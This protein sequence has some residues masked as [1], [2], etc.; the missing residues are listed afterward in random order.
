MKPWC[1][2]R[3]K[4]EKEGVTETVE[5]RIA[6]GWL[7]AY[8]T[9]VEHSIGR[10]KRGGSGGKRKSGYDKEISKFSKQMRAVTREWM[11]ET[12]E[13]KKAGLAAQRREIRSE[14]QRRVR[15]GRSGAMMKKMRE[16][17]RMAMGGDGEGLVK[18]LQRW[19]GKG[20]AVTGGDRSKM[21][22]GQ[23][24]WVMGEEMKKRWRDTF[25]E[26]G[27]GLEAEE[28]FDEKIK[29]ITEAAVDGWTAG[30]AVEEEVE[31]EHE[32]NL[33]QTTLDG[34]VMRWEVRRA[35]KRL[36]DGKA[37]GV[38]GV[39][40]EVL[41]H[42][43]EW[44]EESVWRLCAAVFRGEVVPVE[45]LRAI[46]VPVKK[47]GVGDSFDQYRGVTL[48]SVVGKVFAMVVEA[49]L[50][51][52]CESRGVLTDCQFGFRQGRACRDA[53]LVVTEVLE[54]RGEGERV[55]LGFLDIAKAYPSVWR[56]GMWFRLWEIGVRGRMWRVVRSLYAKCEVAV[57][58]GGEAEDWYEEFVGLREGCVLSPLLFAI[59]INDLPAELE[60][61]KCGGVRMGG[62]VIR[63]LMFAD[64]VVMMASSA[65]ELQ[66]CFEAVGRFSVR[67]RFKFNFGQ[68]KTAVMV[69]GGVREG[70]RWELLGRD[71]QVVQDY[72][73]L[74]VRLMG[75]GGWTLRRKVLL[76][77]AR[78]AF[79]R[80]W[81]LGMGMGFLSPKAARG[82]WGTLVCPV[83]EYG[84]EVDSGAWEDA[85][86]MQR[87]AG[88]MCLGVGR[89]VPNVV[90]RG[91]LGWWT[92]RARREYLRLSYWGKV[93]REPVGGM[94]RDV[95]E[96]GRRRVER[97]EA[98]K[99]EWCVETKRLLGELGLGE[100]WV[101]ESVGGMRR[102]KARVKALMHEREEM[103]WRQEM[104]ERSTLGRYMRV[105]KGLK[106]EWFWGGGPSVGKKVGEVESECD[107]FG[108]VCWEE[109]EGVSG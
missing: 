99:G 83:M 36:R 74:G 15:R 29:T 105:K 56:K 54:R 46:K 80:A 79:W 44:M 67:W 92:V 35:I 19:S 43:G 38:D 16:I 68:D 11:R 10:E 97:G 94:V 3:S 42:G 70:E 81:G 87:L 96:E 40:A 41:K 9:V 106:A 6:A 18:A 34:D 103:R 61:G 59:Y 71:V 65:A 76:A 32:G 104:A 13:E 66:R 58:V 49:R 53:L 85:E 17:E 12:N 23:G 60:R 26:V 14:R 62:R 24:G 21:K 64:D 4:A 100:V 31:M 84:A 72:R 39:V 52:F 1:E 7:Q 73:Y 90:V 57:R 25:E 102:W 109:E 82:L 2:E 28:G 37:V 48:L 86:L 101:T 20:R 93:V 51:A 88:R 33:H 89:E 77:K 108:G 8:D 78:G 22:D 63:C 107:V 95:Y 75:R 69:R 50:R 55:F 47:K 5:G 45:W 30:W 98:G 27:R 91:E